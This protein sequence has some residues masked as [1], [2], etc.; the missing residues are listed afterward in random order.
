[1]LEVDC[2]ELLSAG[3][4]RRCGLP[5]WER[6]R[7]W[8]LQRKEPGDDD[9]EGI[10]R[11]VCFLLFGIARFGADVRQLQSQR[12]RRLDVLADTN[13]LAQGL[14]QAGRASSVLLDE[15]L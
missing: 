4:G 13:L 11:A 2:V 10:D 12:C 6:R 15:I 8:Q 3:S 9:L 5:H 14:R 1:M 7:R